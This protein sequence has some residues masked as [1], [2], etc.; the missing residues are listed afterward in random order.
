MAV[1]CHSGKF[2]PKELDWAKLAAPLAKASDAIARYDSFLGI[3]PNPEPLIAPL[4]VQEAVTSSRI[5]GTQA[6]VQDVLVYEA[7]GEEVDPSKRD[8]I[9]E[10]VNYQTAVFEGERLLRDL[11]ISGRLVKA[12]HKVLLDGVRGGGKSPGLYRND[13]NWIG[14]NRNIDE[15]RYVPIAPGEV[16]NAMGVWERYVNDSDD[17]AL[18]KIAVAHAEF[19][20]IHPFRDGNG[21]VGRIV[22][23]L[24][25]KA[26]GLIGDPCFY[27]SEFFEHRNTEYQDRLLAVSRDD[28]WTEWCVFFLQAIATQAL[29]NNE[30]ARSFFSLY[31]GTRALLVQ[32]TGSKSVDA[33][34]NELFRAPIF[35]AKAITKNPDVGEKTA[36]RILRTMKQLG[37]VREIVPHS[38]QRAAILAFPELLEVTEGIRVPTDVP[39]TS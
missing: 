31:E 13:Q 27:L 37:I 19:E 3:I 17:P 21:R 35:S 7:G 5:E 38:G 9:R 33:I 4:V 30:K 16:E 10:V 6:S 24:M 32:E 8:D 2:P 20:S 14:F 25:M 22:V 18:A 28:A 39:Q 34:V 29:E 12:V 1:H 15:A 36:Q 26:E 11:P 23:P